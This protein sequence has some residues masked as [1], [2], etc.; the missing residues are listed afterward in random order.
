MDNKEIVKFFSEDKKALDDLI[1]YAY[2]A[3]NREEYRVAELCLDIACSVFS[4]T[5][6]KNQELEK[7]VFYLAGYS[8][9]FAKDYTRSKVYFENYIERRGQIFAGKDLDRNYKVQMILN[10]LGWYRYSEGTI[11]YDEEKINESIELF[12][13]EY[14]NDNYDKAIR[15]LEPALSD[16]L[17]FLGEDDETTHILMYNLSLPYFYNGKYSISYI[18]LFLLLKIVTKLGTDDEYFSSAFPLFIESALELPEKKKE[19]L[20]YALYYF[21]EI[22]KRGEDEDILQALFLVAKAYFSNGK[23]ADAEKIVKFVIEKCNSDTEEKEDIYIRSL[24]LLA[25]IYIDPDSEQK[26]LP[27]IKALYETR[28]SI[29]GENDE[30]TIEALCN[31]GTS[32]NNLE[33]YDEGLRVSKQCYSLA[34]EN[35]GEENKYTWISLYDISRALFEL[36]EESKAIEYMNYVYEKQCKIFGQENEDTLETLHQLAYFYSNKEANNLSL[37]LNERCYKSRC[38][39]LGEMDRDTLN[40]LYNLAVSYQN[41]N[42]I[43]KAR[44]L[45][46]ECYTKRRRTLGERHKDTIDAKNSYN[47]LLDY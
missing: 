30:R 38:K 39:V 8:A 28:K 10:R 3:Y 25:D 47:D 29:F 32:L 46:Y 16:A 36:K 26:Y 6:S 23:L 13:V 22:K 21:D 14:E 9:F 44:E 5:K 35:L 18:L 15:L 1:S 45:Y 31:M 33:R 24:D 43:K 42:N 12:Q 40:S 2:D 7:E 4:I 20:E 37:K 27:V 17:F 41:V 19:G 11:T 34:K